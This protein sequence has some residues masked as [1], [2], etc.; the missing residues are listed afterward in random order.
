MEE[1]TD[2]NKIL[3]LLVSYIANHTINTENLTSKA[4]EL[5]TCLNDDTAEGSSNYDVITEQINNHN[6]S[7]EVYINSICSTYIED[8]NKYIKQNPPVAKPID[9]FS[10]FNTMVP[11]DPDCQYNNHCLFDAMSELQQI[12]YESQEF[13]RPEKKTRIN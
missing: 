12:E 6:N 7:I 8:I 11:T 4:K 2:L 3:R 13:F 5:I 10:Q 9:P 1:I